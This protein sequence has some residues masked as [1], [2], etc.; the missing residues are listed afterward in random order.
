[1]RR[2]CFLFLNRRK[3]MNETLVNKYFGAARSV[4]P[5]LVEPEMLMDDPHPKLAALRAVHPVVRLGEGQYMALRAE[6]VQ[7]MLTDPR[8][9]QIEGDDYVRL[10]RIPDGAAARFLA[11]FFLFNNGRTHL[12]RRRLFARAFAPAAMRAAQGQIRAAADTIVAELPRGETFDFVEAMAARVPAELIAGL[13][14]L[15]R[16]DVPLFT[17]YVYDLSRA[18]TPL[19]CQTDHESVEAAAAGLF[20]Y[21]SRQLRD[22]L[23]SPRDDFLSTLVADWQ[24][25]AQGEGGICFDGLVHQVMGI[26]VGGS[27][28]T[29]AA[30]AMLVALL[31]QHPDDWAAVKADPTLIPGAVAEALRYE[32]SVGSVARFTKERIELGGAT[33]PAGVLLRVSTLSALRDP[34]LYAE[35]DRFDIRRQDHPRLHPV[36]GRGPHRCIGEMLARLEMQHGLAALVDA[37]DWIEMATPPRLTGFGGIRQITPMPVTIR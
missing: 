23:D 24:A 35:P 6:D 29:R 11:D 13:L 7:A 25:E 26:V 8:T 30:F 1:V 31:L 15:P 36:F 16:A 19:Y 14:G 32:P 21:V 3:T 27:D 2:L 5:P 10:N 37:V 22:R 28:T 12:A 17:G 4:V 18:V 9:I 20:D 34:A 33:L